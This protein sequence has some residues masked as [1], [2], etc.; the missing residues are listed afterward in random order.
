MV[1]CREERDSWVCPSEMDDHGNTQR[2]TNPTH[3]RRSEIWLSGLYCTLPSPPHPTPTTPPHTTHTPH[4]T[5]PSHICALLCPYDLLILPLYCSSSLFLFT[6][7]I[8]CSYLLFFFN[9]LFLSPLLLSRPL[10]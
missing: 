6:V 8:Y 3:S 7:L 4:H 9:V 2:K 1:W 5:P 10:R